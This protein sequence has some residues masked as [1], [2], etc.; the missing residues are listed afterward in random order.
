M[1]HFLPPLIVSDFSDHYSVFVGLN[2]VNNDT[3]T[4]QFRDHSENNVDLFIGDVDRLRDS[5]FA[6]STDRDS[7]FK[8][9]WFVN[10]L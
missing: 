8:T 2:I 3:F 4:H 7:N 10:N 6:L 1:P 5:Y 9:E